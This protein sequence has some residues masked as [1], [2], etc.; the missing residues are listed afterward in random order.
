MTTVPAAPS[1][2]TAQAS[3]QNGSAQV[4]LQWNNT[5]NN[6]TG[7]YVERSADGGKTWTLIATLTGNANNYIDTTAARGTTYE[8][9]VCAFNALG[10]SPFSN[11]VTV[12]TA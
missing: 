8:Y 7:F 4:K 12:T 6:Q 2:L 11:L 5:S 10:D 3:L 9:E 1:N